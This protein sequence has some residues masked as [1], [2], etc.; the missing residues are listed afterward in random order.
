M[1]QITVSKPW[2]NI[3]EGRKKAAAFGYGFAMTS[4]LKINNVRK[5]R[6]FAKFSHKTTLSLTPSLPPSLPPCRA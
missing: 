4:R 5:P 1:H 3:I 2:R 6:H